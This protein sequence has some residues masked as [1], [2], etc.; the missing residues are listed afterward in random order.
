LSLE[1]KSAQTVSDEGTIG[2]SSVHRAQFLDLLVSLL[3]DTVS[4]Q[5]GSRLNS[6]S[7][8]SDGRVELVFSDDKKATCDVLIA[9]DGIK[10]AVRKSLYPDRPDGIPPRW[11]GTYA[12]RGLVP[13]ERLREAIGSHLTE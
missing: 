3:P 4:C 12:Y 9:F 7:T 2:Q 13:Q 6:N 8:T 5:F 11:T 1:F 10:S